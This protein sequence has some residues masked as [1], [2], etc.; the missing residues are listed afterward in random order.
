MSE[1]KVINLRAARKVKTRADKRRHG[2]ENAAK[3][4]QTRSDTEKQTAQKT[5]DIARLDGHK[6]DP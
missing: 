6:L 4:G 2:N 1:K 3:F 5:I